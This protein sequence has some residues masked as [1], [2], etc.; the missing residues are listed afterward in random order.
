MAKA[1]EKDSGMNK[2]SKRPQSKGIFK[3][4]T[5]QEVSVP[6]YEKGKGQVGFAREKRIAQL[7]RIGTTKVMLH[8]ALPEKKENS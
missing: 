6:V 3:R 5:I 2:K 1:T 8:L 4:G 7:F